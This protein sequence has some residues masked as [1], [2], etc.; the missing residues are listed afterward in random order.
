S[1]LKSF[2]VSGGYFTG[3]TILKL[4]VFSGLETT[5]QAWNGIP[6]VRLN[7]DAA[8]MQRYADHYLYTQQQVDEMVNSGSRTYNLYTYENQ[9]DHYQQNHYQLLFSHQ[10]ND[11]FNFNASLFYTGGKGY[12]EEY[13]NDQKLTDYLIT[14]P[15]YGNDTIQYSDLIRR[16]W[17]DNDFYG[18]TFSMTQKKETSEFTLGGGYNIYDGNHFGKV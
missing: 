10:L 3:N 11:M 14:P 5:Y 18:M 15:V 13:Q 6:S 12:Y 4:N 9:V 8:G 7:N 16:K 1:D 2:F 17:L